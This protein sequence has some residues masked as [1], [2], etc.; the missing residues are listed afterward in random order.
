MLPNCAWFCYLFNGIC[1]HFHI[2][3]GIPADLPRYIVY[4]CINRLGGLDL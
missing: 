4:D 3:T 1:F 2:F